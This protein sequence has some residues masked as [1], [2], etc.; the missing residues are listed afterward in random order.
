[1]KAALLLAGKIP[2]AAVRLPLTEA[3]PATRAALMRALSPFE[4]QEPESATRGGSGGGSAPHAKGT[5]TR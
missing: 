2:D 1:V 5:E 3:G 4:S